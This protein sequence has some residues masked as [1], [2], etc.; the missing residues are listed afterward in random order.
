[1]W[2]FVYVYVWVWVYVYVYVYVCMYMRV[3]VSA[4]ATTDLLDISQII[5]PILVPLQHLLKL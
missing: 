1:V 5:N 2:V 3:C 4:H